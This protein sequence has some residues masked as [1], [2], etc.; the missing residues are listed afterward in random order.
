MGMMLKGVVIGGV[1]G[2]VVVAA[3]SMQSDEPLMRAVRNQTRW[4]SYC[5]MKGSIICG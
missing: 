3:K 1:V 2:A 4:Q 5:A